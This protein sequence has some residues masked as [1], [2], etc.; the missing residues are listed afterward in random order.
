MDGHTH[1]S[2]ISQVFKIKIYSFK[3]PKLSGL[4]SRIY[5]NGISS[6]GA[7]FNNEPELSVGGCM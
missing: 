6:A 3:P 1:S 4:W 5:R 2:S 7:R